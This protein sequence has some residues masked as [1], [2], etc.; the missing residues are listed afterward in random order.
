[1]SLVTFS[2]VSVALSC[3]S[4]TLFG[5]SLCVAVRLSTWQVSSGPE[6]SLQQLVNLSTAE[7][8]VVGV[9]NSGTLL[10]VS[11]CPAVR[12]VHKNAN[13]KDGYAC[14]N[15]VRSSDAAWLKDNKVGDWLVGY[16]RTQR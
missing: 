7:C 15:C 1:M 14:S 16:T 4:A 2:R 6:L 5:R 3:V 12:Q 10:P 13:V 9:L 11:H 8:A